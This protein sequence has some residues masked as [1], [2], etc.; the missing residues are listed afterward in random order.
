MPDTDITD[1]EYNASKFAKNFDKKFLKLSFFFT[2]ELKKVLKS[3]ENQS[4]PL[5]PLFLY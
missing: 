3:E 1:H 2:K 4:S 5:S